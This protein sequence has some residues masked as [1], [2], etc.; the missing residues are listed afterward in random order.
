MN[1]CICGLDHSMPIPDTFEAPPIVMASW[2]EIS[3]HACG[4]IEPD[5]NTVVFFNNPALHN[6]DCKYIKSLVKKINTAV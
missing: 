6:A 3:C 4:A 2:G 5:N 1:K